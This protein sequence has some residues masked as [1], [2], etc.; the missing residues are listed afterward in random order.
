MA[1]V[2]VV[3]F[4]V[5]LLSNISLVCVC[6]QIAGIILDNIARGR[7]RHIW[8]TISADLIVDSRRFVHSL[9]C[10]FVCVFYFE[11][12]LRVVRNKAIHWSLTVTFVCFFTLRDLTDIGCFVKVINGC[13]EL[14]RETR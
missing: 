6:V 3:R 4:V 10:V 2:I 9:V 12:V 5:H 1:K 14:D 7:S 11:N 8:F 13:Q